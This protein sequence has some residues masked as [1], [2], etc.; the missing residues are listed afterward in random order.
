MVW[1]PLA[2]RPPRR[3]LCRCGDGAVG[4][5]SGMLGATEDGG[6]AAKGDVEGGGGH[7]VV[8]VVGAGGGGGQR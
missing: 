6:L 3:A 7:L 5:I 8:G 4:D 2:E 1:R